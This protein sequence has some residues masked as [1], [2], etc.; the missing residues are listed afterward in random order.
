[1]R[2][3]RGFAVVVA[4]VIMLAVAAGPAQAGMISIPNASFESPVIPNVSPYATSTINDWQKA[5]VPSWW[6]D[7][8]YPAQQW[9]ESIGAF[10]NV[11]FAPIDNLDQAQA[12]F[13]F[14]TPGVEL[15]QDLQASFEVGQSYHLTV[16][17]VGGG[18]GMKLGV[19]LE[20]RLYYRNDAGDR[21]T[22]GST[23]VTNAN[24]TG[25]LQHLTDYQLDIPVV[26]AGEP[27]AGR[28]IGVQIISTVAMQDAGGYWD[29]DNVRLM[30][31]PEPASLAV[32]ALGIAALMRRQRRG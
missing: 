28:S 7:A 11:P 10:L 13:V 14:A 2:T 29:L 15:F 24:N 23:T 5:P 4:G 30:A 9:Y 22:V 6:L 19:P 18:Y 1:M 32:M 25:V 3:E 31:V 21:I 17:I 27:W 26:N 8:G 16:G 20:M 12:A